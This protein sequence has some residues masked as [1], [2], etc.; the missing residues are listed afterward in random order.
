M[1]KKITIL[2][3][4]SFGIQG[5]NLREEI[6]SI[7]KNNNLDIIGRVFN[8]K[9]GSV[10]II[11]DGKD[12]DILCDKIKELSKSNEK[13]KESTQSTN[14]DRKYDIKDV[15]ISNYISDEKYDDFKVERSDDQSEMV[16]ALKGAGYRFVKSTETLTEIHQS[17]KEKDK[18]IE[19]SRLIALHFELIYNYNLLLNTEKNIKHFS[20]VA[21]NA[22]IVNPPTFNKNIIEPLITL[23]FEIQE[24]QFDPTSTQ[25][26]RIKE[27]T[28]SLLTIIPNLLKET[29][30]V[31]DFKF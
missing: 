15:R 24:Y 25:S 9:D 1:S 31:P 22:N 11:C 4:T 2:G 29:Y 28:E 18:N 17:L 12:V 16:W 5:V 10:K 26:E 30:N 27:N 8:N 3:S 14:P 7:V 23:F 20:T 13:I 19:A 6:E 21:I